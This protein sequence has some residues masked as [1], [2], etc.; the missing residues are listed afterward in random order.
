MSYCLFDR[1]SGSQGMSSSEGEYLSQC[2]RIQLFA[3]VGHPPI[4][5]KRWL[6]L[7]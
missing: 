3:C 1:A 5:R 4:R 7:T 2:A 6:V